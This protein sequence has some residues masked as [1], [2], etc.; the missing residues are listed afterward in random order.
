MKKINKLFDKLFNLVPGYIFG[1]LTFIIGFG[2]DLIAL[3]LSP[4]Y[5][6]WKKS[7]SVL[8]G[9]TGGIYLRLGIIISYSFSILF[10]IYIGRVIEH[11]N[12]NENFRK[13]AIIIGIFS[14]VS[15]IL[16]ASFSGGNLSDIHGLLALFSWVGGAI[17]YTLISIIMLKNREFSK[18]VAYVGFIT[19]GIFVFYLIPFFIVNYCNLYPETSS[20]YAFGRSIYLIM[21]SLEWILIFSSLFWYLI[22]S[23]YFLYK[24]I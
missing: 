19:A 10:I 7:I 23:S 3:F 6:M 16:T 15:A 21:P 2:G 14:S 12:L 13:S 22:N 8:G 1:L 9:K 17:F 5:L 20:V 4:D 24:K 11:E 18:L